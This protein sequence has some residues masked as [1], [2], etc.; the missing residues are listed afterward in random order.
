MEAGRA[1]HRT[2]FQYTAL[3]KRSIK[4]PATVNSHAGHNVAHGSNNTLLV[5]C[6][7]G[8]EHSENGLV[9]KIF[10]DLFI[11]NTKREEQHSTAWSPLAPRLQFVS[12]DCGQK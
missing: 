6:S 5:S 11:N 1:V 7:N 2:A 12:T 4:C 3:K 9:N 10:R 8:K